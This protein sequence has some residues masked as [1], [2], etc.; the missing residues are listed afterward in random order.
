MKWLWVFLTIYLIIYLVKMTGFIFP[1]L[2]QYYVSDLLA[3]PVVAG[4]S[5]QFMRWLLQDS[6]LVLRA[7]QV[8]F[9]TTLFSFLFEILLPL[10]M[11]RY[12]GDVVDVL[13]YCTGSS[14]FWKA[15]NK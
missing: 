8:I 11:E 5:I 15:M 6:S 9:I 10:L 14:F 2:V 4:L 13:M 3:V 12:T 1:P 7:W